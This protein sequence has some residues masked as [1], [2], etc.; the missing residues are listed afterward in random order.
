MLELDSDRQAG[1]ARTLEESARVL[2]A[3]R[4]GSAF[5]FGVGR[6]VLNP[7]NPLATG[8]FAAGLD[9]DLGDVERTLLALPL[10]WR[11]AGRHQVVVLASPSSAP[12]L[13]LL[14]EECGYEA[15]EET[16][17]MLLTDPRQLVDHEPG[18]LARPL[19][20]EHEDQLG[21]LLARAFDWSPSVGRRLQVV[22]GHRLDDPRHVALAAVE[23]G[24]VLGVGTG[25]LHGATGQVVHVAVARAARGRRLGRALASAVS[26][27][28]LQRGASL[29][30]L[31]AEAGSLTERFFAGLGF[32]PAYDAVLF[33][34][35]VE[36]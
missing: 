36:P 28:L 32:E 35:P 16:T 5:P 11:E 9:G 33:T 17:T 15:A 13:D 22:Q 27:T 1:L 34:C 20:E 18:V 30:W 25:F 7:D 8:S 4:Y 10:V 14:A 29:V 6:V 24:E 26:S 23:G 3:V 2:A 12:E 21:P 19:P 31:T